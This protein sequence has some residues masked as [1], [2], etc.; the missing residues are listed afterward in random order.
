MASASEYGSDS[1]KAGEMLIVERV[2]RLPDV[3]LIHHSSEVI[4]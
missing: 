1:V 3:T 2:T 4:R